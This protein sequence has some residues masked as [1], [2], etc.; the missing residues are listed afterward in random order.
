MKSIL[1]KSIVAHNTFYSYSFWSPRIFSIILH[2]KI[3]VA[4]CILVWKNDKNLNILLAKSNRVAS[5]LMK[6]RMQ[7]I[8]KADFV[9]QWP[10]LDHLKS[11]KQNAMAPMQ[12]SANLRSDFLGIYSA[13]SFVNDSC[14]HFIFF[15]HILKPEFKCELVVVL[16]PVELQ[17]VYF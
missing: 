1:K 12:S 2:E 10:H 9:Y 16:L 4:K 17:L 7:V 13:S 6:V 5:Q 11:L 3:R 15:I 8:A 14:I